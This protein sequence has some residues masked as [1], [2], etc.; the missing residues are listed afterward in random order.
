MSY[1]TLLISAVL[2]AGT[3]LAGL[4]QADIVAEP[5]G[6]FEVAAPDGLAPTR[7]MTMSQVASKFGAPSNKV[8]AV[9][10][11]PI[12]RWD[13]PGFVVYFE[14]DYVIHSVMSESG[15]QAPASEPAAAPAP[16]AP[17]PPEAP[18]AQNSAP[19]PPAM[20]PAPAAPPPPAAAAA[21]P[22]SPAP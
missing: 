1:R 14:R 12:S 22:E 10:K 21:E 6:S 2:A 17:A 3:G 5:N 19:P 20:E 15:A 18:A 11:P 8:P 9:G 4:A 16:A 7:G 13:Y